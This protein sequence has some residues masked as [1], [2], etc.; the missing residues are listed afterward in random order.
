[1]KQITLINNLTVQNEYVQAMNQLT[2][3]RLKWTIDH[4]DLFLG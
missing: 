3:F 1:M 4:K 2:K